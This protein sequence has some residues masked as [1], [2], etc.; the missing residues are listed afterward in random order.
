MDLQQGFILCVDRDPAD[1]KRLLD[2]VRESA[3]EYEEIHE[4][5]S[6]EAALDLAYGLSQKGKVLSLVVA[7]QDLPGI[8][9]VRLL[10]MIHQKFP[11]SI[12]ILLSE[13]GHLEDAV[14]AFNNADLDR[15]LRKPW[16]G[17][18]LQ[19][20]VTSL[21][22]QHRIET[23]NETLL[24][25][26]QIKNKELHVA[27]SS[28]RQAKHQVETSYMQTI[29]SLAIA[30]EAKD[31]YTAGHSQRVAKF[32]G[33]IARALAMSPE[34]I[35]AIQKVALLHDIGK[36]GMIDNILNKPGPLTEEERVI[37][38]S[39]PAVGGKILSPVKHTLKFVDAVRCHHENF[40][41]SGYPDGLTADR[42]S[43][44]TRVVRLADA[45]DAMTS[46]RPYRSA[47]ALAFALSEMKTYSGSQFDP[48][49]VRAFVAALEE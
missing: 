44:G 9:G 42:V 49:C 22:R 43:A 18:E 11:K 48:E 39:H 4:A 20:A 17:E 28:L 13:D 37:V 35:E 19:F 40:D 29:Q 46:N 25:D 23:I 7:A 14:Y 12:K 45:F 3:D 47:Q 21:L 36:I 30:L 6:S 33:T 2:E 5:G 41:G 31:N 16:S 27:L 8:P 15:Y 32:A 24:G 34:D 10:E 38:R 26:L 1:R